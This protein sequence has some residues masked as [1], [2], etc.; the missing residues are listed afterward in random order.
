MVLT[1]VA[2]VITALDTIQ[3]KLGIL[4]EGAALVNFD[5]ISEVAVTTLS[6]RL[7]NIL[8]PRDCYLCDAP[9]DGG[10]LCPACELS[11][12][13]LTEPRCPICALPTPQG[14]A[15]GAC[16]KAPP[17]YDATHAAFRYDFPIDV[18]IHTLKYQYR[19]ASANYLAQQLIAIVP[20]SSPDII[21]PVPLAPARLSTRGFNQSI[22]IAQPLAKHMN[23]R[24]ARSLAV[25]CRDTAPQVSLPRK[26]RAKNIRHAFECDADLGGKCVWVVDDVMTT[27]A[28]L[29]ELA[30]ILKLQGADRVEN[31]VVARAVS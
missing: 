28:T 21:L 24:L 17:H 16:L 19:L 30:R 31:L 8:L 2:A 25:R 11:L 27:G 26:E 12:P 23:L 14:S 7:A 29:N 5:Y 3:R 4:V 10:F 13:R 18:L 20:E 1:V 9:S 22:E 15:C 6:T